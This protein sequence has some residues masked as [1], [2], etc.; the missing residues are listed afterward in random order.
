VT[1]PNPFYYRYAR[2]WKHQ[3]SGGARWCLEAKIALKSHSRF[4][5]TAVPEQVH[6]KIINFLTEKGIFR[7]P[8]VTYA[9]AE[10]VSG[11]KKTKLFI[12]A[13]PRYVATVIQKMVL[14]Y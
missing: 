13:R 11:I 9:L 4:L 2:I 8:Y 7:L 6:E 3:Y 5:T 10:S 12:S 1:K 14:L